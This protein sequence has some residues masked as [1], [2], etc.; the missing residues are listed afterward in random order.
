M[1]NNKNKLRSSELEIRS[2]VRAE[3]MPREEIINKFMNKCTLARD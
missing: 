1:W 3:G 2:A